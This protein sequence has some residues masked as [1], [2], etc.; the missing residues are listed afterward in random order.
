MPSR[1]RLRPTN[2]RVTVTLTLTASHSLSSHNFRA[3]PQSNTSTMPTPTPKRPVPTSTDSAAKKRKVEGDIR[4]N[5]LT[6][7][8]QN[9]PKSAFEEELG[10]MSQE[11]SELKNS[12]AERDQKWDRP[13][14][15][16]SWNPQTDNLLF[17]QIDIEEGH[18]NNKTAIRLF[19]VTEVGSPCAPA[20]PSGC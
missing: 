13:A 11:I 14:L 9:V 3:S 18:L 5:R 2:I 4:H 10:K 20:V 16:P 6:K 17:Q 1:T 7:L 8:S 12:N 15:D 19:G